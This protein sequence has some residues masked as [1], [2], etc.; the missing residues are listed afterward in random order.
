MYV[1]GSVS[2]RAENSLVVVRD[3]FVDENVTDEVEASKVQCD[4]CWEGGPV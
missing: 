3:G 1:C 2:V 4:F